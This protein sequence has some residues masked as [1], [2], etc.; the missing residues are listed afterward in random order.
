M[1]QEYAALIIDLR[2]SRSYTDSDR[3]LIQTHMIQVLDFLNKAFS[4]DILRTVE[5][6]A[7]DEI[8]G[9]FST[10]ESAYLFYR[11]FSIWLYPVRIR[12]GIG[13][14]NW[15]LQMKGR[16]TTSQDGE[17]Y[18]NARN[19]IRCTDPTLGYPVPVSY[20]HLTLPTI[21]LV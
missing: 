8:Q 21:L 13:I 3:F 7:G 12:A 11:F 18:H 6:S 4:G 2:N 1:S 15:N 16:G 19:A 17:V 20:T 9:L 14:G 10:G 5:F